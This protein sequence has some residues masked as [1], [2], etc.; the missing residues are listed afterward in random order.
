MRRACSTWTASNF[1]LASGVIQIQPLAPGAG[2]AFY[3]LT[4]PWSAPCEP[5]M[6][7]P[8]SPLSA[9]LRAVSPM[10]PCPGGSWR[11]AKVTSAQARSALSAQ[12]AK[13]YLDLG[14]LDLA[15]AASAEALVDAKGE[16]PRGDNTQ[17]TV[18]ETDL[19]AQK[20]RWASLT[21]EAARAQGLARVSLVASNALAARL[22]EVPPA[23]HLAERAIRDA[24]RAAFILHLGQAPPELAT[25]L[26]KVA[27]H[28]HD[29]FEHRQG[30][31]RSGVSCQVALQGQA[32]RRASPHKLTPHDKG[33]TWVPPQARSIS[34]APPRRARDQAGP[35]A[36]SAA[37]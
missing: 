11:E 32:L 24:Y 22:G 34:P 18:A 10:A 15:T 31:S 9:P 37:R 25:R 27:L 7:S 14:L 26:M 1:S 6:R 19:L 8:S 17:G 30:G 13:H 21:G 23:Y 16:P 12:V 28:G 3:L 36:G 4:L 35:S 5:Y 33:A 29:E 20:L 2:V